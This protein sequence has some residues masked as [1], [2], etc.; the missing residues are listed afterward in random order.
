MSAALVVTALTTGVSLVPVMLM[1]SVWSA[2]VWPS[3]TVKVNCSLGVSPAV[4]ASKAA[5]ATKL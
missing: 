1:V 2:L 4:S 5:L 3:L